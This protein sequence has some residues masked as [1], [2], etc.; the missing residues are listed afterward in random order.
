M[1]VI[2][3]QPSP[4]GN[5]E[6]LKV[7]PEKVS[8]WVPFKETV[9]MSREVKNYLLDGSPSAKFTMVSREVFTPLI[10]SLICHASYLL[11]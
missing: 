5:L 2:S 9:D 7:Y 8:K 6:S 3:H 11:L 10:I 1:E 4:F